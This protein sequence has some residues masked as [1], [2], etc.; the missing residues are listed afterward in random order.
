MRTW[1]ICQRLNRSSKMSVKMYE[2]MRRSYL[3]LAPF[4]LLSQLAFAG[5]TLGKPK[6]YEGPNVIAV[7]VAPNGHLIAASF[8]DNTVRIINAANGATVKVLKGHPQPVS[9][10]A[11]SP[12]SK[13]LASGDETAR[14]F[15][16]S[17]PGAKKVKEFR[18]HTRGIIGLSFSD[19]HS[20]LLS[21]GRDDVCKVYSLKVGKEIKSIPGAGVNFYGGK[22][23]PHRG[24]FG[25]GTLSTGPRHY[26]ITGQMLRSMK[27]HEGQGVLDIDF[28]HSGTKMI[29]GGKDGTAI[30][31]D[32]A[33]GKKI[34]TLK[35]HED[36]VMHCTFSPS[37]A[38][39]A[40][41]GD[42]RSV[43]I[44]STTSLKQIVK[45]DNQSAV[46]APVAFTADGE[47]LISSDVNDKLE[48]IPV[49][50]KIVGVAEKKPGVRRRHRRRH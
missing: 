2:M 47:F 29:S 10:L 34:G 5:P 46:G 17:L 21:T 3:Y 31:W 9:A 15:V 1:K 16:W 18:T 33:T 13:A 38:Y 12:D 40:T 35:G 39:V 11:W 37:D 24:I 48:F 25:V 19:D 27:G 43:R 23:Q 49:S 14:I 20:L 8:E 42:D 32:S 45:I 22:F 36:W 7:A 4:A 44:W 50:P 28:S 6:L 30:L 41:S 26:L